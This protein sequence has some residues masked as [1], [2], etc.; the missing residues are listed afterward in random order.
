MPQLN[1]PR[2]VKD[3]NPGSSSSGLF[4]NK[5]L[6]EVN[7]SIYFRADDGIHGEELWSIDSSNDKAE[8][9]SDIKT[10]SGSGVPFISAAYYSF[11]KVGDTLY[12]SADN[13][14]NGTELWKVNSS[15]KQPKFFDINPDKIGGSSNPKN[16]IDVNGILYFVARSRDVV[17]GDSLFKIDSNQNQGNPIQIDITNT[18]GAFGISAVN[19]NPAKVGN[20]IY[21]VASGVSSTGENIYGLWQF[22]ISNNTVSLIQ[23]VDVLAGRLVDNLTSIGEKLYFS[24]GQDLW[25]YEPGTPI[26]KKVNISASNAFLFSSTLTDVNGVPYIVAIDNDNKHRLWRIDAVG[27]AEVVGSQIMSPAANLVNIGGTL[28]FN[29]TNTFSKEGGL[30]KLPPNG[31]PELILSG[32]LTGEL[33]NLGGSLYFTVEEGSS[34]SQIYKID[35]NSGIPIPVTSIFSG[36]VSKMTLVN[37]KIYFLSYSLD[38][39][40]EPYVVELPAENHVPTLVNSIAD[41]TAK[42]GTAFNFTIPDNAFKDPDAGDVLVYSASLDNSN[43]LPSWLKFDP[44]T[45]T[46]NG[47]PTSSDIN[48]LNVKVT[49]TDESGASISDIFSINL[50]GIADNAGNTLAASRDIGI[51]ADRVGFDDFIGRYDSSAQDTADYYKFTLGEK[52]AITL[53]VGGIAFED[54]ELRLELR[55]DKDEVIRFTDNVNGLH[56]LLNSGTYYAHV[57]S[58][59]SS[60]GGLYNFS[61]SAKLIPENSGSYRKPVFVIPGIG[62]SLWDISASDNDARREEWFSNRG[63]KPDRLIIDPL[64]ESYSVLID[65]LK[66][67]GYKEGIDLFVVPY[68]WRLPPA[69]IDGKID[70]VVSGISATSITDGTY[71]YGVDYLGYYLKKATEEWSKS[72]NR[73]VLSSVDIIAHS[74]GGLIARTYIESNA[75]GGQFSNLSLPLVDNLI[76]IGVPNSGSP[77][78]WNVLNDDWNSDIVYAAVFRNLALTAYTKL[79]SGKEVDGSRVTVKSITSVTGDQDFSSSKNKIEFIHQ[80]VPSVQALLSTDDF[81]ITVPQNLQNKILLD[82]NADSGIKTVGYN[83]NVSQIYGDKIDTINSIIA[84]P[85]RTK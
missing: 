23:K 74:T 10:G 28:Y 29:N 49:A 37:N 16:L 77:K 30:W 11:I 79:K 18:T 46:F 68:D 76:T 71:D 3:I 57:T 38:T 15:N 61:A 25:T 48:N 14:E 5:S 24:I 9:V 83:G 33:N 80:Y 19:Q 73:D 31:Q 81:G 8:L 84:V 34:G 63:L 26:P 4:L 20:F 78:A 36:G 65:S 44:N 40:T 2:I 41:T 42:Q 45:R 55:N 67:A 72:H 13:G 27:N 47:T 75:Y 17:A 32:K 82:L 39:G 6:F 64:A 59:N 66:G 53:S 1:S 21:T 56:Q 51:L 58:S 22:N 69:P 54:K 35:S 43:A 50:S 52:S 12:F 7:G 85:S 60:K 70:G 62:G